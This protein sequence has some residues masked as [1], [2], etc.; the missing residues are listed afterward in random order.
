MFEYF[1]DV[2]CRFKSINSCNFLQPLY[3]SEQR[4]LL[5]LCAHVETRTDLVKILMDLLLIDKRKSSN[6]L[7]AAEAPYRLYACQSH[8][9][10]SRPQNVEG[11]DSFLIF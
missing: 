1:D 8:V 11:K 9:M 7:N 4:L 2:H 6:Y 5:N 10:Y 3:K